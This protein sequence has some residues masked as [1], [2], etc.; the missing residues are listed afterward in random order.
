MYL[1]K[2]EDESSEL[3]KQAACE[4]F[5]CGKTVT[6]CMKSIS[7][8]YRTHQLM[9]VKEGGATNLPEIWL[10]KTLPAVRFVNSNLS[11]NCYRIFCSEDKIFN[12]AED[13]EDLFKKNLLDR[14]Q[15]RPNEQY[16]QEL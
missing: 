4:V 11:E 2:F 9:P 1:W 16:H 15:N 7:R 5:E 8:A 12:L 10:R 6:E 13:S 14:Y 3:M